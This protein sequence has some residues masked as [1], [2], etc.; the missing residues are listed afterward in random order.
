MVVHN[1]PVLYRIYLDY[2]NYDVNIVMN[3]E[4]ILHGCLI[5]AIGAAVLAGWISGD[6]VIGCGIGMILVGLFVRGH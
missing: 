6:F 2:Y 5:V 1:V 4:K 3:G